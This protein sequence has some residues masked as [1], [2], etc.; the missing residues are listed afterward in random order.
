MVQDNPYLEKISRS[1]SATSSAV[2]AR[3]GIASGYQDARS[4]EVSTAH[5]DEKKSFLLIF[6]HFYW[7]DQKQLFKQ[8]LI[9]L[10]I[11]PFSNLFRKT[12][13]LSISVLPCEIVLF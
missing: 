5:F 4:I 6:V 10:I 3:R 12:N 8:I 13:F 2:A 1:A 9:F 7:F 11:F